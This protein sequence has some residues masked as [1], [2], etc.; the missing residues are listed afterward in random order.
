MRTRLLLG[1]LLLL[2]T[3]VG[4]CGNPNPPISGATAIPTLAPG[5]TLT[6]IPSLAAPPSSSGGGVTPATGAFASALGSPIFS[7][8]CAPCHGNRGQGV[9]APA[10]R[11]NGFVQ[12]GGQAVFS[13]IAD[14]IQGAGM[15][16]WLQDQGG[17]LTAPEID[18]VIAFLQTLQGV[19]SLPTAT[20][21]PAEPTATP[22][23]PG[24]P[25]PQPARPSEPGGPGPAASRQG[26]AD[27]GRP[28][29]GQTCAFCHGGEGILGV[30]NPGSDDG[31]VPPLN[32]IDPTIATSDPPVFSTNLDLFI[33][34]GSVPEGS[35]P[36]IVMPAFGDRQMLTQGGIANVIAYC[37][38]L[39]GVQWPQ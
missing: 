32:P 22:L 18:T 11:D 35:G 2:L 26:N 5:Q 8:H 31:R 13:T 24:A 23:P 1:V 38:K 39:N 37:M 16:A 33:E 3:L 10:L 29:F 12:S 19:A 7:E 27:Q 25:T 28:I 17:P 14:G 34:H 6:L 9:G 30:P 4:A 15:P 36:Q 21:A 20:P